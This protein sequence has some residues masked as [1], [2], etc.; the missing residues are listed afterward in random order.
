MNEVVPRSYVEAT[1]EHGLQTVGQ[2]D[3]DVTSAEGEAISFTAEVDIR[4]EITL[5]SL[6]GIPVSVDD[7]AVTDDDVDEQLSALR[8]RF[9]SLKAVERPVQAGDFVSLDLSASVDGEQVEGVLG[10]RACPTRSAPV[11]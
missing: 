1:R 2:P 6:D 8:E 3:I 5:P 7:A 4:P 9:G 10:Q 11:T